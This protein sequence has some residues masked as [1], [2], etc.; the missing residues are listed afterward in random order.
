[1]SKNPTAGSRTSADP[2]HR[3]ADG[4]DQ[5]VGLRSV[6]D[7]VGELVVGEDPA[8]TPQGHEHPTLAG[9]TEVDGRATI[10]HLD[11]PEHPDLHH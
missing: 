2:A 5:I 3:R 7:A 10:D 6:E 8:G 9:A 4:A 1:M 11:G